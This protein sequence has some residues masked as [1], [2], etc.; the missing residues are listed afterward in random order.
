MCANQAMITVHQGAEE[1]LVEEAEEV[2]TEMNT[3]RGVQG[4]LRDFPG[5]EATPV[6]M[7]RVKI[8][9]PEGLAEVMRTRGTWMVDMGLELLQIMQKRGKE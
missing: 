4:A 1:V 2:P 6:A 9:F 8:L 3:L 7:C 5:E